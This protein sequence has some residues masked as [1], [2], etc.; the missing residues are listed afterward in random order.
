MHHL[1]YG[2]IC[3]TD[4]LDTYMKWCKLY[5]VVPNLENS[6]IAN[7]KQGFVLLTL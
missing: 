4:C 1:V 3:T 7:E 6:S 2:I 5:T